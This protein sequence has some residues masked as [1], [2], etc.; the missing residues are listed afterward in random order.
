MLASSLILCGVCLL[1]ISLTSVQSDQ[2]IAIRNILRQMPSPDMLCAEGWPAFWPREALEPSSKKL[3]TEAQAIRIAEKLQFVN[4]KELTA[5]ARAIRQ[6]MQ[7]IAARRQSMEIERWY[8]NQTALTDECLK[9]YVA[10]RYLYEVPADAWN[11][12]RFDSSRIYDASR[13]ARPYNNNRSLDPISDL[14]RARNYKRRRNRPE[15]H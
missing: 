10:M 3:Q 14:Q 4:E 6:D 9:F 11:P 2:T 8:Y 5:V 7:S 1:R 15:R 12:W 13:V